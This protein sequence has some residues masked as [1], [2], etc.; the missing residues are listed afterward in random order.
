MRKIF[1][2]TLFVAS[3]GCAL[4]T[5]FRL[6]KT[7]HWLISSGATYSYWDE[8]GFLWCGIPVF[9]WD[10][11]MWASLDLLGVPFL[12]LCAAIATAWKYR[13]LITSQ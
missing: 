2:S 10:N 11:W 3:V 12:I 7:I 9:R 4:L 13:P 8:N 6:V 1:S 5:L